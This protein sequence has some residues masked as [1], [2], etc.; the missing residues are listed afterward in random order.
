[1][2]NSTIISFAILALAAGCSHK[3]ET[4]ATTP[5]ESTHAATTDTAPI[6][7][8]AP[9]ETVPTPKKEYVP[10]KEGISNVGATGSHDK[11]AEV[12]GT[13]GAGTMATGVTASGK[14]K[15]V[16]KKD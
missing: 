11:K 1:M 15:H 13:S 5:H 8:V 4:V 12:K 7:P 2:K 10:S 9:A 16:P 3:E 14:R 6:A